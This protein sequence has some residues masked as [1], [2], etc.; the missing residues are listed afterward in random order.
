[1]ATSTP[2][3]TSTSTSTSRA[4]PPPTAAPGAAPEPPAAPRRR[5]VAGS[6]LAAM[7]LAAVAA[8]VLTKAGS[9]GPGGAAAGRMAPAFTLEDVRDPARTVTLGTA[10]RPVAVNFFAAWCIPCRDELALLQRASERLAGAVDFVGIDV[11]DSRTA[12]GEL[13][14][15]AGVTFPA[16][17]DPNRQ[18]AT[19]Y[20]VAGM[21][22]TVFVDAR[23]RVAEVVRGALTGP[24]LHR[25]LTR[26][27]ASGSVGKEGRE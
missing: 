5:I 1:M 23:G 7:L 27:A 12:A 18:V 4:V 14:D 8:A 22:T 24:E 15:S 2:T 20:R 3:S 9:D 6:V 25:R 16:G 17:Y 10:G 13:L 11:A 19:R 21:P 26:L